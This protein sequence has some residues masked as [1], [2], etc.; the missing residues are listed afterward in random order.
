MV[1]NLRKYPFTEPFL[2][3]APADPGLYVL[4]RQDVVICIGRADGRAETIQSR[5]QDHFAGRA[6]ACSQ[7]ATHYAW[8]ISFQPRLREREVV[9]AYIDA[10]GRVPECNAHAA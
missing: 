5:L 1:E 10:R 9:Q 7:G 4:W 8:E 3:G 6:C 2:S